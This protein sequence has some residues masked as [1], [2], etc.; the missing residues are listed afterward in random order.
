MTSQP[1]QGNRITEADIIRDLADISAEGTLTGLERA[2]LKSSLGH[3]FFRFKG[4]TARLIVIAPN[5]PSWPYQEMKEDGFAYRILW[6]SEWGGHA[7]SG[8]AA[9]LRML[10]AGKESFV[11]REVTE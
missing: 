5:S 4:R 8:R 10:A 11:A 2:A 7:L 6:S 3:A 9:A 1:I